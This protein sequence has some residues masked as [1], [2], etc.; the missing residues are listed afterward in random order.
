MSR[1]P[2]AGLST[3]AASEGA[4]HGPDGHPPGRPTPALWALLTG[5][6]T[7]VAAVLAGALSSTTL[8]ALLGTSLTRAGADVAG[9][10]CVGLALVGVPPGRRTRGEPGAPGADRARRRRRRL[11]GDRAARDRLPRRRRLR[12]AGHRPDRPRLARGRRTWPPA[13]A[14]C[15]PS[16]ARR[17]C[18]AAR[19]PGCAIR[20]VAVRIVPVIALLGM[21]TP[22]V[23]GHAS[24]VGEPRGGGDHRGPARR[25]GVAVGRRA[26]R[27]HRAAGPS[28]E[29]LAVALPRFST[30]AGACL[31]VVTVSGVL[32]AQVRLGSWAALFLTG[33][34]A[35]VIAKVARWC[36][37]AAWA[38]HPPPDGRRPHAGAAGR[39]RDRADGRH[40]RP[41]GRPEPDVPVTP[42]A[43]GN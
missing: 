20:T 14:P 13:G 43:D 37:S 39:G 8:P 28:A 16:P 21:L 27:A 34:G 25:G 10:A 32:T 23:T 7:V 2:L 42:I 11:A 12:P 22:G 38:A 35:L 41:R 40:A 18:S 26:R 24:L 1:S 5:A 33:Y 4:T 17:P 6:T 30:L 36:C 31:A 3:S 15:S 29:L 9:V 19:S